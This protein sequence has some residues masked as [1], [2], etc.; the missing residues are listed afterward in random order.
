V[1]EMPM[2]QLILTPEV[3]LFNP[4]LR[5]TCLFSPQSRASQK[6][7]TTN[8]RFFLQTTTPPKEYQTLDIHPCQIAFS[9]VRPHF[10]TRIGH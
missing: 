9:H 7:P 2:G 6:K 10:N 8:Q 1:Q 5:N 4:R 3:Q